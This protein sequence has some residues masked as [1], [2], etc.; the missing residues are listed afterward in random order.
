MT[1]RVDT[2][3]IVLKFGGTSVSTPA[4]WER[5]ARIAGERAAGNVRVLIVHSALT[6]ITDRL[7]ALLGASLQGKHAAVLDDIEARHRALAAG[8]GIELPAG[9]RRNLDEL[10]Q[11]TAGIALIGEVSARTRARV[12]STGELMATE[13]GAAYLR[14]RGLDV[15]RV[16]ARELLR[17]ETRKGATGKANVLSATCGYAPDDALARSLGDGARIVITQGFIASDESG[18]TVLLGRGGSDTSA[19][20]FAAK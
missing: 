6:G 19:A 8:L 17:A 5:I 12:M 11:L 16:D 18:H 13:L 10:R 4:N 1:T 9:L 15:C 20:Y 3:W 2:P 7:D 14:A